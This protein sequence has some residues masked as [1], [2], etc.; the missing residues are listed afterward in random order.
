MAQTGTSYKNLNL[1]LNFEEQA[2]NQIH[3]LAAVDKVPE[4]RD[5]AVL[6]RAL[7]RY[8]KYWLP[9]AAEHSKECLS[10]PLDIE[11]VW[12][13]HM[14]SPRAYVK[15]SKAIA[16]MVV[17]HTLRSRSDYEGALKKSEAYW[18]QKY[19]YVK[20]PF[21]LDH[22]IPLD[23]PAVIEFQSKITYDIISS[24]LRQKVFYYQVSLPHYTDPIYLKKSVMRY[25]QFL[26]LK[27]KHPDEFIVPCYD[28][29]VM[30]HSHQLNPWLYK[31]ETMAIVGNLVNHDDNV[32]DRREGSKLSNSHAMTQKYWKDEFN[33]TFSHFGAMYR[34]PPA[35]GV[36]YK[37]TEGEIYKVATKTSSVKLQSIVLTLT[38]RATEEKDK[39]LMVK[40]TSCSAEKDV[41]KICSLS[42]NSDT[43]GQTE[44]PYNTPCE[45]QFNTRFVDNIKFEVFRKNG[46]S[47]C[48]SKKSL[49]FSR[50]RI[51]SKLK[52]FH[53]GRNFKTKLG[54]SRDISLD[55][56]GN[57]TA[58]VQ[59]P[60][61]LFVDRGSY[62]QATVPE[63]IQQLW[64]PVNLERLPTG[65]DNSC[66][67][68][69]HK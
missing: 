5:P 8:E 47:C 32:T 13:C 63:N 38:G 59:G 43:M 61:L 17:N 57:F 50:P 39:K 23:T 65:T 33:E 30:W 18:L 49:G 36:L 12:H 40:A 19:A 7:H 25:K 26:Y 9:L 14:L 54:I 10:A 67:I 11:W 22:S 16:N 58:P 28:I 42:R 66:R 55:I 68:A 52:T 46:F 41:K 69:T 45:F 44:I 56:S 60:V 62:E 35:G 29:D 24:A 31:K 1:S 64:G 51:F 21:H 34:G 3:F 27:S 53:D 6:R 2:V 4:L 37:M 48:G 20:E 15:D